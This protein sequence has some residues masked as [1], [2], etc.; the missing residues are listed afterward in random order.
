M[1]IYAHPV[2]PKKYP[3][4]DKRP[5]HVVTREAL[6]DEIQFT[7]ARY[8]PHTLDY[9]QL[10]EIDETLR[11]Y[12]EDYDI[13]KGFW[14]N[15]TTKLA[16]NFSEL[17]E[18]IAEKGLYLYGFWGIAPGIRE[19]PDIRDYGFFAIPEEK[20][21]LMQEV[22]GDHFLGYDIGET[23]GWY[24]GGYV[25]REDNAAGPKTHVEQYKA[26][27]RYFQKIAEN[28]YNKCTILCALT[29]VHYFARQGY[30]TMLNCES[31]Q[32]LPNPQMWYGFL[33]G[34]SKQYG[35][36]CGGNVSVWNRWGYKTY[37]SSGG[38]AP[39]ARGPEEGTSLSLM[40]RLMYTEYMYGC[41]M[42]GFEQTW[43]TDDNEEMYRK[44]L[45]SSTE[46]V[47]IFGKLSPLG[48]INQ[49]ANRL[50]KRIGRPGV[51]HTPV[52]IVADAFCGWLPPRHLY[53]RKLYQAWGNIPYGSGDWQMNGLFDL[54]YPG[55][56]DAGFYQDERGFLS[57]TPYG[58]ITDV[59]LSDVDG[60]VLRRY[61]LAV[62]VNGTRLTYELY[63]KLRTFVAAGGHAV[64]FADTVERYGA[65]LG[66]FDKEA[67]A[68]FGLSRFTGE[69]VAEGM[70]VLTAELLPEATV[71]AAADGLPLVVT[72]PCGDGRVTVILARDGLVAGDTA[73]GL[74][75]TVEMTVSVPV[76]LSPAVKAYLDTQLASY[77]L[78]KASDAALQY[79][80]AVKDATTLR[81]LVN[82]NTS[83]ARAFDLVDGAAAI[84]AVEEISLEDGSSTMVGYYPKNHTVDNHTV[85]GKGGRIIPALDTRL[86]EVTLAEPL[87]LAGE[88]NPVTRM[89]KIGVRMPVTCRS[90]K[91]F[92]LEA[93]TFEQ[94][95][96]T[97]LV[98]GEYFERTSREQ[99]EQ[100]AA[101]LR[102]KGVKVSVD[103]TS[104]CNHFPDFN[105]ETTYPEWQEQSYQRLDT[106]LD[107]FFL[108]PG[109]TVFV[110]LTRNG[111]SSMDALKADLQAFWAHVARRC[112]AYG[113][114]A[115]LLNRPILV[116][117]ATALE[118]AATVPG[119]KLAVNVGAALCHDTD[120]E[121]L[122]EQTPTAVV[123]N[124][125]VQDVVGQ[126]YN[127]A[128][129]LAGSPFGEVNVRVA[130][131]AG[132]ATVYFGSV[133]ENWDEIYADYKLV[134]GKE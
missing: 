13:G 33:R 6:G 117:T 44:K 59:L 70:A 41:E 74:T 46:N 47:P 12:T 121:S 85:L 26:F 102:L 122:L 104:L 100:D 48:H 45:P 22:L 34:A 32:S 91:D 29:T 43:F 83:T 58:E 68:F 50:I 69:T 20:H 18:K 127:A 108:C 128:A 63:D 78:V 89:Q 118:M 90:I 5:H 105:F 86:Y 61:D 14:L 92:L 82:N 72:T 65:A 11:Q 76:V 101:Y 134:F 25:S 133:Y 98:D 112:K 73:T 123:L 39:T 116:K 114:T 62:L 36:L 77:S 107:R 49:Y 10:L 71:E 19:N 28:F 109:E 30:A 96:D 56:A 23:D 2:D 37:E 94:Y 88:C 8:I 87:C 7:S 51:L 84:S 1:K 129:P 4:F 38:T 99:V 17:V 126:L 9:K 95:F 79:V 75:N 80:V 115:A 16:D 24:I 97:V 31:A 111:T 81:V 125:P 106:I 21:E 119:L 40:K 55:Y 93:P 66:R 42:F 120:P 67:M 52:A 35:I 57:A 103:L 27:Q 130:H 131:A 64:V 3:A 132:E 53:T 124:A 110:A 60:E 113:V 54:L 15:W